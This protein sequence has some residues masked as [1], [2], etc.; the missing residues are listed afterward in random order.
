MLRHILEDRVA[1]VDTSTLNA[2]VFYELGVRHALCRSVTV[3]IHRKGT[4]WPFNIAGLSSIEYATTPRGL[5]AARDTIRTFIVN[6]LNDPGATDSLVYSAI[7]D[8]QVQRV[9]RRIGK[10]AVFPYVL[11]QDPD[12]R[13]G[14][15]TGDREDI[16]VGDVWVNSE[17]THMQM[18]TFFGRSTSATIRYLGARKDE[19][20]RIDEDTIGLELASK[21]RGGA[22]VAPGTVL[23]T[24]AGALVRN[25][26][27]RIFHVAAVRGEPREGYR[28]VPR[29]DQCVKNALRRAG[30]DEFRADGLTSILFPVFGTG[31]GRG[32]FREHAEICIQAA[33]EYLSTMPSPIRAVYFYVW[34]DVDLDVCHTIA[35]NHPG[36]KPA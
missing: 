15:V 21:V 24:G 27:K 14:F 16:R 29:I 22:E 36:L 32:D 17:N 7:P 8:L 18:D 9:P 2:N 34:G 4:S 5:A 11:V 19:T 6:A 1:I 23:V 12:R 35:R 26:V 3:L 20:G 30:E 31:P 10:L 25:G 13:I 33:V 28:P